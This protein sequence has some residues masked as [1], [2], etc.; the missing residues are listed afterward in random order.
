MGAVAPE[1]M[2]L[3]E[4]VGQSLKKTGDQIRE[5]TR[6]GYEAT[7]KEF[8]EVIGDKDFQ[9]V[10]LADGESFRQYCLDESNSPATV[11]KKLKEIT[12]MFQLA[13]KRRQL[14]TNPL[15]YIDKPK[16]PEPEIHTYTDEECR[17][18]VKA[19]R[20]FTERADMGRNAQWALLIL[21]DLCTGLPR[22]ELCNCLWSDI[23]LEEQTIAVAPKADAEKTW[24]WLI[25]DSDCRTVPLTEELAQMLVEH[26]N[27]QPGGY[28]YVF[29]PPARYDHIQQ[30]RAK[31]QWTYR[32]ASTR[33]MARFN[34]VFSKIPRRAGIERGT[35][36]DLRRTAIC[37][38]FREGLSELEVKTL[39]GHADFETTHKYYLKVDKEESVRRARKASAQA[40]SRS[41]TLW[42]APLSFDE[43]PQRTAS[44]SACEP[45]GYGECHEQVDVTG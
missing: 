30:L 5:S 42:H 32:D 37:N 3:S 7:M 17:R 39:A 20:E 26:Q 16:C 4:F 22:G 35:F 40:M 44:V 21:V 15:A 45:G 8:I 6:Q 38:W 31:R 29:I 43:V 25:K 11:T 13:V 28:P 41:G 14:E 27:R 18:L 1:S 34:K 12:A 10:T 24:K 19:A 9:R 33:A 2:R 36:H 23:D